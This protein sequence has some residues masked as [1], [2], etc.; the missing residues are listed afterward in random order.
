MKHR[1]FCF[2]LFLEKARFSVHFVPQESH[3]YRGFE[4]LE[5]LNI[6]AVLSN[7]LLKPKSSFFLPKSIRAHG[8][9]VVNIHGDVSKWS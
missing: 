4:Y 5:K 8:K 6:V 1:H 7:F 3:V 9:Q 2:F